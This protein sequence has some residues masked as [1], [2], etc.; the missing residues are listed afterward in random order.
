MPAWPL[1]SI[2]GSAPKPCGRSAVQGKVR[3]ARSTWAVVAAISARPRRRRPY[4]TIRHERR[5]APGWRRGYDFRMSRL[6]VVAVIALVGSCATTA[7][8]APPARLTPKDIIQRSSPA[9]VRIEA[10]GDK[11]GTGF[12][13]DKAGIVATNLH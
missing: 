6:R 13:V 9:I 3:C 11:V 2:R 8:N 4:A 7:T 5:G 1:G 10:G 12:I